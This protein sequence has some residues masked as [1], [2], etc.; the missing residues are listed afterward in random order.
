MNFICILVSCVLLAS[1][2]NEN[3]AESFARETQK[4]AANLYTEIAKGQTGSF[5]VSPLSVQLALALAAVG[6][7][8]E[9]A[10][11]LASTLRIP[12]DNGELKKTFDEVTAHLNKNGS[13]TL[14]SANKVYT[15]FKLDDLYETS[16]AKFFRSAAERVNF[17]DAQT[18]DKINSWVSKE[19]FE[20]IKNL[21]KPNS[22]KNHTRMVLIN[23][24]YFKGFW[25]KAFVADDTQTRSFFLSETE[26]KK[27]EMME[28]TSK[29]KYAYNDKLNAQVLEMFYKDSDISMTIILPSEVNGLQLVEEGLEEVFREQSYYNAKV[30]VQMP[31]F[32]TKSD[33]K[34]TDVLKNMGIKTA[35]GNSAEFTGIAEDK[36][37]KI[38]IDEV[39]QKAVIEVDEEGTTAVAATG[40]K[41]VY[42]LVGRNN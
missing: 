16:L 26:E 23:T 13:Y 40:G 19:T 30:H 29:F 17:R 2:E 10:E 21:V 28:T 41:G 38:K 39:L 12:R 3:R 25:E 27:V 7:S 31:K 24:M 35:F 11:E 37:E 36:G 6:A 33:I 22:F 42:L 1:A 20:K 8:G 14:A 18:V 9:T 32:V 34:L 4:F 5:I 15:G